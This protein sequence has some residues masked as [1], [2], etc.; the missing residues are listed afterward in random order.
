MVQVQQSRRRSQAPVLVAQLAVVV[1][2]QLRY[3]PGP[4][5]PLARVGGGEECGENRV[6]YALLAADIGCSQQRSGQRHYINVPG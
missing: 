2:W 6:A 3:R 1:G 4:D 5:N